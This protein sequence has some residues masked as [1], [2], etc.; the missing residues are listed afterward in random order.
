M[1]KLLSLFVFLVA[2][3]SV[4]AQVVNQPN[5]TA[6]RIIQAASLPA[7]CAVGD[8]YFK[9]T[10]TVGSYQCLTTNN[11]T[12]MGA[13]GGGAPSTAT[14]IT[15]TA[16][17]TLSAEQALG[18]LSTGCL[19]SATTTGV[20]SARTVTGTANQISVAN[21]DCSGN[22]TLS[23][24][25]NPTLP[26]TTTGTFSGNLTGNASG[27]AA[28]I[29]GLLVAGNIPKAD[30]FETSEFCLDA[31]A[32][33]TYACNLSPAVTA[34]VTGTHYRFKA[35]TINT[36]AASIN[37]NS[38]GALTIVKLAGAVTTTLADGDI[39][40]GQWV[41]CVYDGTNCQ[42]ESQLGTSLSGTGSYCMT[43]SCTMVTPALGTPASGVMTN[44]TGLA[45]AGTPLTT[46]GDL[47]VANS[48][49]ALARLATGAANTVL[50][51]GTDPSYSAVVAADITNAT[52]TG[53]QI[54]SSV[55]LAG[56]PTTTTQSADDNSTKIATTAYVDRMK[57]RAIGFS[58]GDPTNPSALTT[59]S[60]SQT[61][62]VP[63]AC[64]ISAYALAF[65]PGDTGTITVKFWKVATGTAIPTISN[66]IN[67]SGVG[68]A[69]GTAN[70][71]ATVSDF[72]TTTVTANDMIAMV[73]TA[74]ATTKSITGVLQC[75]Q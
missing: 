25:T 70:R 12:V 37:F 57:T 1:R 42:M 22:P 62:T 32:N 45:L 74:V 73:V 48:T 5:T 23:I 4:K 21:G 33:D 20:V 10:A 53:T 50:H 40:A 19:G 59:S 2:I 63:F 6:R 67:T 26:G 64:T 31:G 11:W 35:N 9:N 29:T 47:L 7:T 39:R 54:A 69:S 65:G 18:A 8:I 3:A 17:A 46:R 52:I 61:V 36:G 72:T 56:S 75:D 13:G 15:Q 43:T 24:P 44:M 71:S 27:S 60:V 34:Y 41:E 58:I 51:G 68:I 66:V 49:P 28:T 55:A 16:D 30:V 14:Y 38:V